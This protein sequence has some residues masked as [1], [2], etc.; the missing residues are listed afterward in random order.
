MIHNEQ[1]KNIVIYIQI[2]YYAKV[3]ITIIAL[4]FIKYL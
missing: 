3:Y 1:S 4:I 2:I